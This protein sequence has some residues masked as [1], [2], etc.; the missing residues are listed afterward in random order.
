MGFN[1]EDYEDVA[2][3]NRWFQ[4]NYPMG[5]IELEVISDNPQQERMVIMAS[6][7]RDA[8]DER[9]AVQNIARGK[10]EEYNRNMARFYGEDVATSAIGRAILLLKGAEKTAHKEGVERATNKFEKRIAEKIAVEKPSDP[11]S[12]E[13]KEM[14]LPVADAVAAIN[15]NVV[16]EEVPM[17]PEHKQAGIP[18]TGNTRGKAWK[19]YDCPQ[20]WPNSCKWVQWMEIDK[21]GRWVPQKPRPTQGAIN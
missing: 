1:L 14:P 8:S 2:T 7:Y 19:K 15:D 3:L 20:G 10:Q 18:K 11:W 17:C 16:P 21:T 6:I 13:T 12:I 5:R 4:D 9:P